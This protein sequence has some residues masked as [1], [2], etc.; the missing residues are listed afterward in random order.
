M[1]ATRTNFTDAQKANIYVRDRG[2]CCFSGANLWLMDSPLRPGWERDWVDHVKPAACGGKAVEENGVC[3]SHSFNAKKGTNTADSCYLF[4]SGLPTSFYYA[5]YGPLPPAQTERLARLSRLI[6]ADWYLNRAIG[7]VLLAFDY[8]CYKERDEERPVRDD[9]YWLGAATKK[10]AKYAQIP[11]D[12][13]LEER[14]IASNSSLIVNRWLS[15]RQV[16]STQDLRA[17]VEPLFAIYRPNF[18]AWMDYFQDSETDTAREKALR[19]AE[20]NPELTADVL[21][22]LRADFKLRRLA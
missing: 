5:L 12:T 20:D 14:G 8:R 18:I 19:S 2:T 1:T 15:L 17:A 13:T 7:Q 10:L 22:C 4:E 9:R 3:A 16:G 21:S 11:A 6:P